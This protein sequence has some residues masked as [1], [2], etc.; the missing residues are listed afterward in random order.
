MLSWRNKKKKHAYFSIENSA[1]CYAVKLNIISPANSVCGGW[2]ETLFYN[3]L[4][5]R[6]LCL[7]SE[8]GATNKHA[9]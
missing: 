3:C 8:Q 2:G 9:Y 5:V 4:F 1:F 7:V 6:Q